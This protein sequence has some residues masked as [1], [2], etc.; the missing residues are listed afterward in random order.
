MNLTSK[1]E[2]DC[3]FCCAD[4]IIEESRCVLGK[5]RQVKGKQLML[6]IWSLFKK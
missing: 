2:S 6:A 1:Y 4:H 5:M 3:F